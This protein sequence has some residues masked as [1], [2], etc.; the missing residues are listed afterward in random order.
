MIQALENPFSPRRFD[1]LETWVAGEAEGTLFG[2]NLAILHACAAAGRLH[3]PDGS[4]I[5]IEDV[6]ERPYRL[7]RM[8]AGLLVGGHFR[9]ARGFIVGELTDC[10]PGPDGATASGVLRDLLA[11]LGLPVVAGFPAGHG[12]RNEPLVL[13]ARARI[14]AGATGVVDLG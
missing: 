13:G 3:V 1:G 14:R 4:I 7:D 6:T 12:R 11:P 5:F 9:R 8:L 10:P 2:G